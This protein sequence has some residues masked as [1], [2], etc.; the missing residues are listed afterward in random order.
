M[1]KVSVISPEKVLFEGDVDAVTAPAFDGEVGILTSH[2]PMMTLLGKGTLEGN[3]QAGNG[4]LGGPVPGRG[5][6]SAGGGR[7]R[8]RGDGEGYAGIAGPM[9][10]PGGRARRGFRRLAR[11]LVFA[12]SPP[13]FRAAACISFLR[14]SLYHDSRSAS[15][16]ELV[17]EPLPRRTRRTRRILNSWCTSRLPP[18]PAYQ[19]EVKFGHEDTTLTSVSSGSSLVKS[20]CFLCGKPFLRGTILLRRTVFPSSH[21]C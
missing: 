2:A 1:L 13:R 21:S 12:G 20:F 7:P 8:A 16:R 14:N 19:P 3:A 17:K 9:R 11:P 5:R 6:L 4:R 18:R 15:T 10:S